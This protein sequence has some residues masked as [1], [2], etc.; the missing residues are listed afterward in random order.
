MFF[1]SKDTQKIPMC[2]LAWVTW[3]GS[4]SSRGLETNLVSWRLSKWRWSWTQK[5]RYYIAL[6]TIPTTV[7]LYRSLEP[8][9]YQIHSSEIHSKVFLFN[10]YL[11]SRMFRIFP[12]LGV[13][14]WISQRHSLCSW[15]SKS[16]R[17][18][19]HCINNQRDKNYDCVLWIIL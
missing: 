15:S 16:N 5:E 18:S 19:R 14:W 10:T 9:S 3:K 7:D 4:N 6:N 17:K 8:I 1:I 2:L 12:K 13:Q 11:L